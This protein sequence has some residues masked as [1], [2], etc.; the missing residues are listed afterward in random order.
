[1][2]NV[3]V[4][5]IY[6]F[7]NMVWRKP[8]KMQIHV[9]GELSSKSVNSMWIQCLR[10]MELTN[11]ASTHFDIGFEDEIRI[12]YEIVSFHNSYNYESLKCGK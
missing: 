4:F 10:E 8:C 5:H 3:E 1:M 7:T 9:A 11:H 2:Y 12:S 6:E